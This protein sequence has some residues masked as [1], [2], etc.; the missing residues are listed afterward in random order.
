[1]MTPDIAVKTIWV[2]G[3]STVIRS[4]LVNGNIKEVMCFRFAEKTTAKKK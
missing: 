1:M 4:T 3:T 2:G